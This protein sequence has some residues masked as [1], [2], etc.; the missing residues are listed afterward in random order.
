MRT[1][2]NL[3]LSVY[4]SCAVFSLPAALQAEVTEA[5]ATEIRPNIE[6]GLASEDVAVRAWA[7]RA[8]APFGDRTLYPSLAAELA[9][10]N[11][12]IR[13]AAAVAM[14]DADYESEDALAV[15][16]ELVATGD[17]A[18]RGLIL[19][20]VLGARPEAERVEVLEGALETA[21]DD[22]AREIIVFI[23]R[24]GRGEVYELLNEG[25]EASAERRAIYVDAVSR[26]RRPE[27]AAVAAAFLDSRDPA[28]T[29][30]G[31]EIAFAID[32]VETRALLEDVIGGSDA[33]LAQRAGLHL[34]KFGNAA[35]LRLVAD[36]FRNSAMDE[37][38]RLQA[39]EL[40]LRQG[41]QMLSY[42]E[43]QAFA[44][45][46]GR[47]P[48]F[49]TR[50]HE[51]MGA[52]ADPA[53]IAYLDGR[54]NALFA[55]ER[56]DGIAGIGWCGQQSYVASLG[57]LAGGNADVLLRTRAVAA[58][59]HLGGDLAAQTLVSALLV[60]RDENVRVAMIHALAETR[61]ELAAQ[62]IANEFA[63]QSAPTAMAALFAL[64]EIGSS[65]VASQIE[66]VA[67]TFRDPGVRW[68]AVV[69]L[70]RLDP[71]AGRIRLLQSL[72]RAPDGFL[73]DLDGLAPDI[74]DEVNVTLLRHSDL[75]VRE[76]ALLR[77]IGQPDGGY[78]VLRPMLEGQVAPE[79]RREAIAVVTSARLP[80]DAPLFIALTSDTDRT[81]RL[82]GLATLAELGDTANE[83]F[84][85]GYMNHA[86]LAIRMVANYAIL[87]MSQIAG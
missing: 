80:E 78:S 20:T 40:L 53:A 61:S 13:I 28:V 37:A 64:R 47:S 43:L 34:A 11:T 86:D 6:L 76:G 1:R 16:T 19:R 68:Q 79:I 71:A 24:Y 65:T 87:R 7:L 72:D 31:A 54:Y 69:T 59:G 27:G 3:T 57:E 23:A 77:V 66:S 21:T 63:R 62:P 67:S 17:A 82:Q 32:T 70:V 60:E 42:T 18:T 29:A 84:F 83:E 55:D 75:A 38:L 45:E 9:N 33:A 73:A 4:L 51:L 46:E 49:F 26:A 2:Q 44:A 56:L 74:L 36:L 14:L 8:I 10:V 22:V 25:A 52:T 15:L 39:G 81:V 41:P 48:A 50:V 5:I 58:L 85:R 30:Q 35:A 12:P